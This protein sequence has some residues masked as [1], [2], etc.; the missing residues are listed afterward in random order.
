MKSIR[1][2]QKL[3][4][5][6]CR[7]RQSRDQR[8][9]A[10]YHE[11]LAMDLTPCPL[12]ASDV[13][14]HPIAK[15]GSDMIDQAFDP[16][17]EIESL[18]EKMAWRDLNRRQEWDNATDNVQV[19]VMDCPQGLLAFYTINYLELYYTSKV[20]KCFEFPQVEAQV[21]FRN[22]DLEWTTLATA[23]Q[24]DHEDARLLR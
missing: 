11:G 4:K 20:E 1:S 8:W 23:I 6:R 24:C 21:E 12:C 7:E 15:L 9:L 22:F 18:I 16:L 13:R 19:Y 10:S 2:F 14:N 5:E 3:L 17:N